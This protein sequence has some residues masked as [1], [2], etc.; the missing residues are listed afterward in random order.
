MVITGLLL[1]GLYGVA[2]VPPLWLMWQGWLDAKWALGWD[3]GV[4]LLLWLQYRSLDSLALRASRAALVGTDEAPELHRALEKLASLADIPKPCAAIVW[5]DVPDAFATGRNPERSTVA[6]TRGLVSTLEPEELEAVL[7]HELS[8]V[9]NRDGA[10][11]TFASF[12]A[13]SLREVIRGASLK[14][15]VF[16]FPL[17]LLVCLSYVVGLGIMLTISRCREYTADR[18]AVLLTGAPEQ[19]MSA[20]QKIAGRIAEIPSADLRQVASMSAFFIVPT[21][22]RALTHPPLEKR[23]AR[24]AEMSRELGKP[25]PP[26]SDLEAKAGNALTVL[27]SFVLAFAVFV[28]VGLLLIR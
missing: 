28:V 1:L 25:V 17:M 14:L 27:V 11:M 15:W 6:I 22:L 2:L 23:L 21:N 5:S 7:A 18:G 20:L 8:H 9:A 3:A 26:A 10:V 16:G 19:L 13:L 24:L 12:P 4:L